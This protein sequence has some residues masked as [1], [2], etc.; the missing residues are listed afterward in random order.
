VLRL[1]WVEMFHE[2]FSKYGVIEFVKIAR[3]K[4][5]KNKKGKPKSKFAFVMFKEN[6]SLDKLLEDG[7]I[8]IVCGFKIIC[9]RI[10]TRDELKK[11]NIEER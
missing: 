5:K 6:D 8:H 9:Q 7:D 1:I 2:Y 11:K 4:K 3:N 10:L